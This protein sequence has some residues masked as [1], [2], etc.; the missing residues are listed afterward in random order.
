MKVRPKVRND[1]TAAVYTPKPRAN[2][3]RTRG[4]TSTTTT[5]AEP[6]TGDEQTGNDQNYQQI[7]RFNKDFYQD[8]PRHRN[9]QRPSAKSVRG[10]EQVNM[11]KYVRFCS[12]SNTVLSIQKRFKYESFALD[13]QESQWSTKISENS[14]RPVD[15]DSPKTAKSLKSEFSRDSEPDIVTA[16]PSA[17]AEANGVRSKYNEIIN[18]IFILMYFIIGNLPAESQLIAERK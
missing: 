8:A 17:S 16:G 11:R 2:R 4:S 10:G 6:L 13:T 14:F 5:T 12:T 7:S 1:P 18:G 9:F 15:A 3:I